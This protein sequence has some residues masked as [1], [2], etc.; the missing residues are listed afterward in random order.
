MAT[1]HA[2]RAHSSEY[3]MEAGGIGL[4]MILR[5]VR[6]DTRVGRLGGRRELRT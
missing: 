1:I 4:L 5:L 2:P 3:L 6:I